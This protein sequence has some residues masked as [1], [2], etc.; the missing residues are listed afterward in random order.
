MKIDTIID[1][2]YVVTFCEEDYKLIT[3]LIG[4]MSYGD[5]THFG[6]SHEGANRLYEIYVDMS[7][8]L[9]GSNED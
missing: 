8:I 3:E 6:A 2:K 1:K 7:D 9:D 4:K 5:Y